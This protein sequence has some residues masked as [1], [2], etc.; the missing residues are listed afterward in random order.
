MFWQLPAHQHCTTVTN[1]AIHFLTSSVRFDVTPYSKTAHFFQWDHFCFK[2]TTKWGT[3]S[4]VLQLL[5]TQSAVKEEY[6]R[7]CSLT[8]AEV[9]GFGAMSLS[10]FLTLLELVSP[11]F[12]P[13][14][15]FIPHPLFVP[16][17]WHHLL[18]LKENAILLQ[19]PSFSFY[20][21]TVSIFKAI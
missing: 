20:I 1:I 2:R 18:Y 3:E 16:E 10:T 12:C 21:S 9:G 13:F 6:V 8:A 7:V 11:A 4:C 14:I 17:R 5:P 15:F 19:L